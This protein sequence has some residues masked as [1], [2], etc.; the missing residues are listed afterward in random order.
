MDML[1]SSSSTLTL[2]STNASSASFVSPIMHLVSGAL[3]LGSAALQNVLARPGGVPSMG[4][5][6]EPRQLV[7]DFIEGQTP[8]ALERLF[9]NIGADGC[10]VAGASYGLVVASP[11][12]EE[13]PCTC[14]VPTRRRRRR[15]G[16]L[17]RVLISSS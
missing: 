16:R 3:L 8:I 13:P 6:L 2:S 4:R 15:R 12:K 17:V 10:A 11:S 9:C 5:S 1:Y 7:D 14:N